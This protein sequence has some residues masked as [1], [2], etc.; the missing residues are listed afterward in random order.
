MIDSKSTDKLELLVKALTIIPKEVLANVTE[1]ELKWE[2]VDRD[3]VAPYVK[4]KFKE[5]P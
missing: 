1:F 5:Q 2:A 3:I 4:I